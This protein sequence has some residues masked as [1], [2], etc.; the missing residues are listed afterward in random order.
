[1]SKTA[2]TLES[3][4]AT[5]LPESRQIAKTTL[6]YCAALKKAQTI[7]P[8]HMRIIDGQDLTAREINVLRRWAADHGA[9]EPGRKGLDYERKC[10]ITQWKIVNLLEDNLWR[11]NH[12]IDVYQGNTECHGYAEA[13]LPQLHWASLERLEELRRIVPKRWLEQSREGGDED[14]DEDEDEGERQSQSQSQSQSEGEG[15]SQSQDGEVS[16]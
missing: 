12:R 3:L 2:L 10:F 9:L 11:L 1:M 14:E 7:M 15:E 6:E 16:E 8:I 5:T 4:D 13:D